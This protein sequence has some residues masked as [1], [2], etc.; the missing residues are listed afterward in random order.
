MNHE[1][2]AR[3]AWTVKMVNPPSVSVYVRAY[4]TV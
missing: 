3:R 2:D 1:P 4:L